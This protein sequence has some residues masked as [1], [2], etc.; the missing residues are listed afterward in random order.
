MNSLMLHQQFYFMVL[1]F[2]CPFVAIIYAL[3]ELVR[4]LKF[5]SLWEQILG[6]G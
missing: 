6:W 5:D 4:W 1:D 3:A 2:S